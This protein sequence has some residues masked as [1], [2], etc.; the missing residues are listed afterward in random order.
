MGDA[1]I[2]IQYFF[3]IFQFR[4]TSAGLRKWQATLLN[5]NQ[6]EAAALSFFPFVIFPGL[7]TATKPLNYKGNSHRIITPWKKKGSNSTL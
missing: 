1:N 3:S 6:F 2:M 5:A 7:G 4:L